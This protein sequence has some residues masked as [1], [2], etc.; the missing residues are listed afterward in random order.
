MISALRLR[1]E[2]GF[3]YQWTD[4]LE[5]DF[6]LLEGDVYYD[7]HAVAGLLKLFFRELSEPLFTFQLRMNFFQVSGMYN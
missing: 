4:S 1:F 3:I 5:G 7:P 2:E 6:S